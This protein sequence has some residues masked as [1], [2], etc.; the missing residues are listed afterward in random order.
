MAIVALIIAILSLGVSGYAVYLS[1]RRFLAETE[2]RVKV[3]VYERLS[4]V[5]TN[6]HAPVVFCR[7]INDGPKPVEIEEAWMEIWGANNKHKICDFTIEGEKRP[8][9]GE[10]ETK[11]FRKTREELLEFVMACLKSGNLA[12]PIILK[13]FILSTAGRRYGGDNEFKVKLP[14]NQ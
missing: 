5:A 13:G 14:A 11:E 3:T 2:G 8:K 4:Y 12:A 1:R 7:V 9:L 10:S 6:V